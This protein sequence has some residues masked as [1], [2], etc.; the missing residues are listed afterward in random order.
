ME[1]QEKQTIPYSVSD[2]TQAKIMY[3]A[4]Y[5][6]A[7]IAAFL[8]L[9]HSTVSSW[10]DR[11]NWDGIAPVGRIEASLEARLCLL[12]AKE[13]KSGADFKEI[14]LLHRQLERSARIKKYSNG[15]GNEIDLNP[16]LEKRYPKERKK[17]VKNAI[18]ESQQQA[19]I[20]NFYKIMFGYQQQWFQAGQQYR[21]RN[22]LKSRQIGATYYFALE[23]LIDA[24]QT[25]RN[26]IF[27]SASKKQAM[28]FRSY[29]CDFASKTAEVDLKGETIKFPNQ[30]ELIFL[31]TNSKTAQSY[32]GNLYFD[33]I[34][35][36]NKFDE[37]RKVAS[38]MASQKQYRQTYISTPSSMSHSAYPFWSGQLF[39]R[40]RPADQR[41]EFDIS[42]AYLQP[43]R[44][45]PDGQWRQIVTIYDAM[46]QGCNL[47]D[48]DA[49][50]L[51]Y[52]VEEFEQLF[53]CQFID[54]NSSVF[55]F[56]DLQKCGVDSLEVWSDFNPL[57]KRPFADNPVWIGYD[58]A[59]TGDRA[60]LAV[61]APPAVEGGKYRLLHYKTVHGMDFEQQ[62]GLIKDYLQIYNVQKI[63]IDR[64][65]L[66]EG[67]YQLVRKF[68]PLTR[69]LTYNVDLKNEMVL[70]TLNI[71]GKRRL[72]FD[73][74]DKEVINSFMTIKKQT[75]RTG[76]KITYISDRSKEAS[77]G[78]I[79]WAIMHC[80]MNE[81]YHS[82]ADTKIKMITFS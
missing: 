32:H 58:P 44:L 21:I 81:S 24:L 51:E 37:M 62:A 2:K 40:G 61:V 13:D 36:V 10:R 65:G 45:M 19:L 17:R 15:G 3:F 42:H 20:D 66:G 73:S 39:N 5:R 31:G 27:L 9:P 29:I 16:N 18:S 23:A 57:A 8:N 68:Y 71:I 60:A 75:T 1:K 25:G 55:K 69:G 80:L 33:E 35:W 56:I 22:I 77:H 30:A 12:I 72:E 76:Q 70:K 6:L 41:Q 49:L 48:V 52:S 11:E 14:D 74:G 4:G 79:A 43:G 82:G 78:D 53:L 34:F 50:K 47:F 28:Q 54:D 46:A 7:D 64:T 26:Q 67:V 63:T 59:H 38:G